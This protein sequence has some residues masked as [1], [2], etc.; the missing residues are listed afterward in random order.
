[1]ADSRRGTLERQVGR[2]RALGWRGVLEIERDTLRRLIKTTIAATL[3]WEAAALLQSPRPV[4][5]SLG[6]ILAVQVTVRASLSRSIQLTIAVTLGLGTA[7]LLGQVLGLHWWSIALVVLGGLV[8]GELFRLG[9][10]S[11]QASISGLLALSLGSSYGYLRATDT[12]LGAVIGVLVNALISPPSYVQQA[13]GELRRVGEDLAA[14]LDDIGAGLATGPDRATLERWLARAR[15]SAGEA[16]KA[17]DTVTQGEDSL[18]FNPRARG[19]LTTLRRLDEARL[20]LEHSVAQTRGI[21]RSLLDLHGDR[22]ER[23]GV[24]AVALATLG[25]MLRAA[26][27]QVSAFGRLQE[28]LDRH[29]DRAMWAQAR[30]RALAERDAVLRALR[31]VDPHTFGGR[32]ITAML[33]NAERLLREVDVEN[34]PHA[35]AAVAPE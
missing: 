18:R 13:S 16:R 7:V 31:E 33:V 20:A 2:L 29:A 14:V 27:T 19:E 32:Q 30:D 28:R 15:T 5:G 22:S 23:T 9:P 11:S 1:M 25:E 10:F 4:L 24:E 34:G 6:A 35:G 12:A 21:T 8:A 3:A 26:A 17:A